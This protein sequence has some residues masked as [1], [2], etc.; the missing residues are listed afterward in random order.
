MANWIAWWARNHVAANLLMIGIIGSGALAFLAMEREVWPTI[1]INWVEVIV[2]WPGAAPQEVEEQVVIRIEEALSDLDSI[3]RI[4][5]TAMEGMAQVYIEANPKIDIV[6]FISDVKLR[7]DSISTFPR[8]IEKP[9]VREIQT[10]HEIIRIAVHGNV[11]E[12]LLKRTADQVRDEV[13]LLAGVQV[14]DLFGARREEVSIELSE[15]EMRR[16]GLTFDDVATAIRGSSVNRSSGTV[17]TEAGDIMLRARNLADSREE[18][19]RIVVHQTA[20]GAVVRVADIA[21]VV[22]GFEDLDILATLNG[23]PGILVQVMTSENMNVVKTSKSVHEWVET[24]RPRMPEG[25]SLTIWLDESKTYFDRMTTISKA[26]FYGLILVFIVLMLSLRPKVALWVTLGIAT[27]YAGAFILLPANDVSLNML[28]TFAFL[29]VL[30]VIVDDAI[31]VGENIHRQSLTTGGGVSA[32]ILGTQLVAKP[33]IFAVL[34]TMIAFMPWLFLSG[35]MVQFT[36]H[37]SIII[38]AAL[39]FSLIEALLILPAHLANMRPRDH[40]GRFGRFQKRIADGFL[41]FAENRYRPFIRIA[42]E[43]RY[44]TTSIFLFFLVVSFGV[45]SSGWLKFS[46]MPEV[47]SEMIW[48]NVTMPD[49]APYSRALEILDQLQA[50]QIKLEAEVNERAGDGEGILIENWY[51][52]SRKDSVIAIVQLAPPEIRQMSAKAAAERLRELIGDIPDAR[53]IQ[54]NFTLEMPDPGL[55]YSISAES[56]DDLRAAATALKDKLMVYEDLYDVRDDLQSTTDEIRFTLK[57]GAE[58]LGLTLADVSRQVRQAYYGEEVQRLPRDGGDVRVM[59]HYPRQTR[60]SLASLA[61][62]RVRLGDGREIPLMAVVD[63]EFAPGFNRIERRERR[64]AAV[65]SAQLKDEVRGEI[66]ED[67]DDNFFPEWKKQFPNVTLGAVGQ[68]EG[69]AQF[70]QEIMSL[71]IVALFMMYALIAIAFRSYWEPVIIMTAI[72]FAFMGAVYGHVIFGVSI[73]LFS[74]FGVGAAAGVVVNDNLVLVDYINRLR[75]KGMDIWEAVMEAGVQRFRPIVITSLTTFVGLVP[76]MA[77]R[78]T[79]AQFLKPAVISLAFGVLFAVFVTLALVPSLYAIGMDV[80]R[81][82]S[83]GVARVKGWFG[84]PREGSFVPPGE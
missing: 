76:M 63:V 23:E 77:E 72:P 16:Y 11:D 25:I 67:L 6:Q 53:E 60:R 15:E 5:A 43:R 58:R 39:S 54:V 19:E 44:L 34:T 73:S 56:F 80:S 14:V 57:P 29:L 2:P 46:F 64:R 71:Y 49:G 61:E 52:R 33:V 70:L 27:A 69:E 78:S 68:A 38:I 50:A 13:V 18:F 59:V 21:N 9:R 75:D 20:D 79:Q 17:R 22:D 83:R 4:R 3:E 81:L 42:L 36:R 12:R 84:R 28:S 65:V 24:A 74:Y 35:V 47:E 66:M 48:V 41:V 55:Q 40:L 62:F 8:D 26:G 31:I 82:S 7:I 51:T 10:R 45:T 30:G 32:A 1:R 37:I